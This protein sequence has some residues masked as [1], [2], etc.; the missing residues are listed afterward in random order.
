MRAFAWLRARPRAVASAAVLSAGAVVITT[1]AFVYEGFPTTEVDLQRRRRLGDE[2]VEPARRPLQP[3]VAGAR[4]RSSHLERRVRH[5]AVRRRRRHGR[6]RRQRRSPRSIPAM[7]SLTDSANVPAGAKV[8][9]GGRDRSPILDPRQGLALGRARSG[10]RRAST[11]RAPS[12]TAEIGAD[13]DVT[14]GVDGTVYARLDQD[15]R[16]R[17]DPRRRRGRARRRRRGPASSGIDKGA[18]VSIT[19][20]GDVA[21][22]PRRRERHGAQHPRSAHRGGRR[23]ATP[24]LQQPSAE[25]DAVIL[26]SPDR[27]GARA[28]RRLESRCEVSAKARGRPGRA[29]VPQGL[30]LRRVVG[31]GD[32]RARLRRRRRRPH[33]A[34]RAARMRMPSCASG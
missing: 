5:P 31:L 8:V 7:V 1:M 9:L 27:P 10:P 12:P 33:D 32:V 30:R 3:R 16:D 19:A 18:D 17:H 22:R 34:S 14:V 23:C 20:V 4:R 2:A 28:V 29:G 26:A 13:G 25:T 24:S 21:G 6:L 15:R 11:S